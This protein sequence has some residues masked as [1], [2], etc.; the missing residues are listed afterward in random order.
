M[1]GK[2]NKSLKL[3]F[4]SLFRT[5]VCSLNSSDWLCVCNC[6]FWAGLGLM[7]SAQRYVQSRQWSMICLLNSPGMISVPGIWL[8]DQL[9]RVWWR[10]SA[11]CVGMWIHHGASIPGGCNFYLHTNHRTKR[12]L[13][14]GLQLPTRTFS[15]WLAE[16]FVVPLTVFPVYGWNVF[17]AHTGGC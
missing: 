12:L 14:K 16:S 15:F 2:N 11:I 6:V 9:H 13:S 17:K 10:L 8:L 1:S 5:S 4:F 3:S 7:C